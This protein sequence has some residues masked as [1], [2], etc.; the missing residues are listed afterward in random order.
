MSHNAYYGKP[1]TKGRKRGQAKAAAVAALVL[2]VF[3]GLAVGHTGRFSDVP[4]D[5]SQHDAVKHV[6]DNNIMFGQSDT[7]FGAL[8]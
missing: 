1:E 4:H 5:H 2:A 6:Y 7:S 8:H 3:G